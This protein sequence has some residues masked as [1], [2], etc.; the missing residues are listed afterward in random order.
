[1][2]NLNALRNGGTG[3][4]HQEIIDNPRISVLL[5]VLIQAKW[6]EYMTQCAIETMCCTTDIPFELVLVETAEE[7]FESLYEDVSQNISTVMSNQITAYKYIHRPERTTIVKDLNAGIDACTGDFIVHTAND[8]FTRPGWLEALIDVFRACPDAGVA[9]LAASDLK[10]QPMDCIM[11]GIYGPLMMF[12]NDIRFDED[13]E[14]IFSDSD[15]IMRIYR[16]GLRSYRNWRVCVQHLYQ[17]TYQ[18]AFTEQERN[19]NFERAKNIF[20]QKHGNCGLFVYR[21]FTEGFVI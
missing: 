9:T 10:Q 19:E 6:Q 3:A 15:L 5:P 13:Y 4:A 1:M 14:N 7:H 21:A 2:N 17:Q 8:I 11:E 20:I 18:G 16:R 12:R